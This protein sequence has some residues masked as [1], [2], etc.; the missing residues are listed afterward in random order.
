[1][2]PYAVGSKVWSRL[3]EA[4][5]SPDGLVS[6]E[7]IAQEMERVLN[8]PAEMTA[9]LARFM[10]HTAQWLAELPYADGD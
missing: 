9:D 3:I 7:Q 5:N 8:A 6:P 4:L 2:T 1:L 10:S